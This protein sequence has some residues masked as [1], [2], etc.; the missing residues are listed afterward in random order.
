MFRLIKQALYRARQFFQALSANLDEEDWQVLRENLTPKELAAFGRM[1]AADQRHSL[2]VYYTLVREGRTHPD[3]LKAAL[4]HDIGKGGGDIHLWHRVAIVLIRAFFPIALKWLA[5]PDGWRRPFYIHYYHPI[6]GA[7][8]AKRLG[9]SPLTVELILRHQPT[10][11]L[12]PWDPTPE[13]L[14][15]LKALQE[16]DGTK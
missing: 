8:M 14:E 10:L 9:C 16:V 5:V 1:S 4:L 7:E 12:P 13:Q 2:E 3:L 6:L 11:E 15:L